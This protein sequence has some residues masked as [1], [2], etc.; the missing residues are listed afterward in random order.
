VGGRLPALG[1]DAPSHHTSQHLIARQHVCMLIAPP[2]PSHPHPSTPAT[3]VEVGTETAVDRSKSI[4]SY[5]T[6]YLN[7]GGNFSAQVWRPAAWFR[8]WARLGC[9][10]GRPHHV[11]VQNSKIQTLR[12]SRAPA[13]RTH[14][15]DAV[16][17]VSL[18]PGRRPRAATA[19]TGASAA[20]RRCFTRWSGWAAPAGTGGWRWWWLQTSRCMR[21]GRLRARRVRARVCAGV[22]VCE[23]A[24]AHACVC[25]C[26]LIGELNK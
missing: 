17:V 19:C 7:D 13:A 14:R 16:A 4:A 26:E 8:E 24:R 5:L 11:S 21:R 2:P 3:R 12:E 18:R 1:P 20:R 22:C 10:R 15:T 23:C 25:V 9:C 6:K